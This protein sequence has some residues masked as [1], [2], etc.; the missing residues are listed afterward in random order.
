MTACMVLRGRE[1]SRKALCAH[2]NFH[3]LSVTATKR[4]GF[5]MKPISAIEPRKPRLVP[6][7]VAVFAL[8]TLLP[9][10]SA[11]SAAV[12]EEERTE[13]QQAIPLPDAV[14]RAVE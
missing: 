12:L 6:A 5:R 7:I 14:L 4:G 8:S 11:G 1:S 3:T 2:I 13:R 10:A 9:L